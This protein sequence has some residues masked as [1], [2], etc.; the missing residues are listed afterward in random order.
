MSIISVAAGVNQKLHAS[1]DKRSRKPHAYPK[2]N[3]VLHSIVVSEAFLDINA[4]G[5]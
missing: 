1:E 5:T 3:N 2:S 4:N